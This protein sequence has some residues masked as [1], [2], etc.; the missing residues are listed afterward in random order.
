VY[1]NRSPDSIQFTLAGPD[2]PARRAETSS[3][4]RT[5]PISF[6]PC[7]FACDPTASAS[8]TISHAPPFLLCTPMISPSLFGHGP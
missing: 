6:C 1:E 7:A 3:A 5:L 4:S 2:D 8:P